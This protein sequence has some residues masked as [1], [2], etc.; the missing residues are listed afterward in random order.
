MGRR[1]RS[2]VA[3]AAIVAASALAVSATAQNQNP[4]PPESYRPGLGDMM[5]MTVQPRHTKLWLAGSQKNWLYADYELHELQEA[6]DRT[7]AVWPTWRSQ[8]IAQMITVNVQD[9]IA[10]IE[11]AIKAADTEKFTAAYNQLTEACDSCHQGAG[12]AM[13]VIKIPDS[14]MFP[15]QD[16]A[17]APK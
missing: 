11:R 6:F 7:A 8:P 9:P 17:P 3:V 4:T 14:T 16:F 2:S 1:Y 15:D 12:R 10:A 13:I 5:T